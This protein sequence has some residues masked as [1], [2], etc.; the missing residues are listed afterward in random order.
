VGKW[1]E[2]LKAE[3][4]VKGF[5]PHV[6]ETVILSAAAWSPR[7]TVSWRVLSKRVSAEGALRSN[8]ISARRQMFDG[9][10]AV[11]FHFRMI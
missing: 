1:E 2:R 7:R 9:H 5:Q 3:C 6:V 10:K 8:G 11:A 4:R